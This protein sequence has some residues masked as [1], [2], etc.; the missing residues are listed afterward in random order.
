[1]K[2]MIRNLLYLFK[3]FKTAVELIHIALTIAY[4]SVN[5]IVIQLDYDKK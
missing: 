3:R 4:T 5:N 2:L 1:M